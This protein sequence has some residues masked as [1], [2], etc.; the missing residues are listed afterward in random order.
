MGWYDSRHRH[1]SLKH[2]GKTRT[3]RVAPQQMLWSFQ[4]RDKRVRSKPIVVLP[5][6]DS[7]AT[8]RGILRNHAQSRDSARGHLL[9]CGLHTVADAA[10][11]FDHKDPTQPVRVS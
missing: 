1:R 2:S 3:R 11:A 5:S 9:A 8:Q 7:W 6:G 4:N 10:P